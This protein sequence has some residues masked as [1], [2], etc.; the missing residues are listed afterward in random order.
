MAKVMGLEDM[1]MTISCEESEEILRIL[2]WITDV[3]VTVLEKFMNC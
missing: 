1:N 3:K 2:I